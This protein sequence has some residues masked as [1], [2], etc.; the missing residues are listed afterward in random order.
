MKL[1]TGKVPRREP[2]TD[3]ALQ[4]HAL[5]FGCDSSASR[6]HGFSHHAEGARQQ[7]LYGAR[8]IDREVHVGKQTHENIQEDTK[9]TERPRTGRLEQILEQSTGT[10]HS[11]GGS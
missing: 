5:V 10:C 11:V 4:R 9:Q 3:T 8:Q 2:Q 1:E 7:H 6:T